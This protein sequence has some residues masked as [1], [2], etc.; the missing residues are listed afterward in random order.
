MRGKPP[1]A[2]ACSLISGHVSYPSSADWVFSLCFRLTRCIIL[3][4][5]FAWHEYCFLPFFVNFYLGFRLCLSLLLIIEPT[6]NNLTPEFWMHPFIY[7]LLVFQCVMI[8]EQVL[9][10]IVKSISYPYGIRSIWLTQ[11][12][13]RNIITQVRLSPQHS[14]LIFCSTFQ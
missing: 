10:A 1:A 5:C 3:C 2:Y 11:N 8:R 13:S 9:S 14:S 7:T 4:C 6:S 12:R